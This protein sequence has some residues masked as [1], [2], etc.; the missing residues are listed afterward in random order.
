[1][2]S[3]QIKNQISMM[4]EQLGR[5]EIMKE[6]MQRQQ[7]NFPLDQVSKNNTTVNLPLP[8]GGVVLPVTLATYDEEI[9][10]DVNG[11]RYFLY[12]TSAQ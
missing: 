5:F 6:D 9:E 3:T 11:K 7:L 1:M 2:D 10:V 4:I 12:S 8:S